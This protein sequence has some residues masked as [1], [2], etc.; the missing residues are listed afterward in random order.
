MCYQFRCAAAQAVFYL[1]WGLCKYHDWLLFWGIWGYSID[2]LG[3]MTIFFQGSGIRSS[4]WSIRSVLDC[5]A[6][7]WT[8]LQLTQAKIPVESNSVLKRKDALLRIMFFVYSWTAKARRTLRVF[9]V[10]QIG[11]RRRLWLCRGKRTIRKNHQCPRGHYRLL[12]IRRLPSFI[13]LA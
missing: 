8:F 3:P 13:V 1:F 6:D 10:F 7:W 9:L 4:T 2:L 5:T 11:T 12:T